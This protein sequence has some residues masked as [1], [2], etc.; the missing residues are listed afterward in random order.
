MFDPSRVI[1]SPDAAQR[2]AQ[3]HPG[4]E[5]QS[6]RG[7]SSVRWVDPQKTTDGGV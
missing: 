1:V 6:V 5:P 3:R 4:N 2:T 7:E